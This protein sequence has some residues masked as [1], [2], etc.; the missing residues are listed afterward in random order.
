MNINNELTTVAELE[1][2]MVAVEN[3]FAVRE[4]VETY[5]VDNSVLRLFNSENE[6]ND[7]LHITL[8]AEIDDTNKDATT[9]L[10]LD[11]MH[12]H[13]I[14]T[15]SLLATMV[16]AVA[17]A[18]GE[19][20]ITVGVVAVFLI[21]ALPLLY[22]SKKAALMR[23]K[24]KNTKGKA[25]TIDA[26]KFA[27]IQT[28]LSA[29]SAVTAKPMQKALNFVTDALNPV[30]K[31]IEMPD[32]SLALL[33]ML[34][35]KKFASVAAELNVKF[36]TSAFTLSKVDKTSWFTPKKVT[37]NDIGLTPLKFANMTYEFAELQPVFDRTSQQLKS[38]KQ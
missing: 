7:L 20:L 24:Y 27:T 8:P 30:G 38:L 18:A 36:D 1:R 16:S 15:E 9:T 12:N 14:N 33:F 17:A 13:A 21:I 10:L 19:A 3:L 28:N 11:G 22:L 31:D 5:G 2:T 6:L 25:A 23:E 37:C 4:Y 32:G 29:N 26:T 34:D 35:L